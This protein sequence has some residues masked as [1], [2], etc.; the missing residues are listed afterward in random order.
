MKKTV[1]TALALALC[2][3]LTAFA[4]NIFTQGID[5]INTAVEENK[6]VIYTPSYT[7]T[8]SGEGKDLS[9]SNHYVITV[10]PR[11]LGTDVSED[12]EGGT[13]VESS[14]DSSV[15]I[16]P[17]TS[18]Q[19]SEETTSEGTLPTISEGETTTETAA[20]RES[21][22]KYKVEKVYKPGT[23]VNG[24][25]VPENGFVLVFSA[26]SNGSLVS[27]EST[28][29]REVT[30]SDI[31]SGAPLAI[32]GVDF[33]T[34]TLGSNAYFEIDLSDKGLSGDIPQTSDSG[35]IVTLSVVAVTA[36][37]A[38]FLFCRKRKV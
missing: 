27:E 2:F 8:I 17:V 20:Y 21:E 34:N 19:A 23:A 9:F 6:T 16:P 5:A 22:Y 30:A 31:E 14:L 28:L 13:S 4:A 38:T 25:S 15:E 11:I 12:I 29:G 24:V 18:E 1:I 35:I 32:Y 7:G 3:S 36:A 37:A 26:E 10:V 33:E